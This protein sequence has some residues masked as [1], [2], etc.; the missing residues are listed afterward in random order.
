MKSFNVY[1]VIWYQRTWIE[2]YHLKL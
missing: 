2:F 1:D